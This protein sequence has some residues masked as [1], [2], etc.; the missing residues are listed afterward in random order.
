MPARVVGGV[1]MLGAGA[2]WGLQPVPSWVWFLMKTYTLFFVMVWFRGTFP[3]LRADQLMG[4][5]WKFLLPMALLNVF[6][7]GIWWFYAAQDQRIFAWLF[8]ALVVVISYWA[9]VR[10]NK[11]APLQ[12]RTYIFAD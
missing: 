10:I 3:R 4:F 8:S 11:P 12:H 2:L 5:A 1:L 6:A 7:A 9:L